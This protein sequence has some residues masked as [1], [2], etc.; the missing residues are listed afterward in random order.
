PPG[1]AGALA[2]TVS[3]GVTQSDFPN[4]SLIR[5]AVPGPCHDAA[6]HV[7]PTPGSAG[8]LAGRVSQDVPA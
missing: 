7:T 3:Q 4:I 8:A 2:G 6:I 1:S 5:P